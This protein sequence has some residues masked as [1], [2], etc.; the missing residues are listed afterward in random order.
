MNGIERPD[1]P[2]VPDAKNKAQIEAIGSFWRSKTGVVLLALYLVAKVNNTYY[3]VVHPRHEEQF[4]R[5][6]RLV[7][8]ITPLL[9]VSIGYYLLRRLS[10]DVKQAD[11]DQQKPVPLPM[12]KLIL[13]LS[14][15]ILLLVYLW[16][17]VL[18]I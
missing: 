6:I 9:V 16:W 14:P 15:A 18:R 8:D 11:E 5:V 7:G 17:Q 2:V 3:D 13:V 12:P 10:V 1:L 4:M